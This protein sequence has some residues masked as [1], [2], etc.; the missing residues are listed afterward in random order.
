M[1]SSKI[2]KMNFKKTGEKMIT[3]EYVNRAI[4]YI[5][6]HI[7]EEISVDEVAKHC[8]FS[9][10]YFSRIFKL[11]TGESIYGFIKR[12]KMEQSA[13]RLKVEKS[14]SITDIGSEYGYSS[15]NFSSAFKQ[16]HDMSPNEFRRNIIDNSLMHPIFNHSDIRLQTFGECNERISIETLEDIYVI[17]ER[18]IGNYGDLSANWEAFQNKYKEYIT[19]KTLFIERTFDDPSITDIDECL[20]DICM[21]IDKNCSLE[22]TYTIQGG[23]FAIYHFKGYMQEIYSTYQSIFNVWI[24]Q[25]GYCIDERYSFEIYRKVDCTSKYMEIDICIPIK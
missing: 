14:R 18:R 10:Y 19:D 16:H 7:N 21:S 9:K 22:N 1:N 5:L 6:N 11:M 20:Y 25:S 17:Y 15:S 8:N 4:D 2:M 13:F 12:I 23:K 3:N 24:W